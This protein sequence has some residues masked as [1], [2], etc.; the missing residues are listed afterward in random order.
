MHNQLTDLGISC[1]SF[2][3]FRPLFQGPTQSFAAD[4]VDLVIT[5]FAI[6]FCVVY[7]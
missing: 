7:F 3:G 4:L 5:P 6:Y 2:G 1:G